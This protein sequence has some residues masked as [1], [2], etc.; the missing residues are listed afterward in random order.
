MQ[1]NVQ[2][3]NKYEGFV[4]KSKDEKRKMIVRAMP[5]NEIMRDSCQNGRTSTDHQRLLLGGEGQGRG[6]VP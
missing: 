1:R 3:E 6:A 5:K 4:S 2:S